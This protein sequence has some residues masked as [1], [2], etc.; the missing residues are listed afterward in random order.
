MVLIADL[1]LQRP[2]EPSHGA[3]AVTTLYVAMGVVM[4]FGGVRCGLQMHY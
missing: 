2:R 1:V 3:W 4:G